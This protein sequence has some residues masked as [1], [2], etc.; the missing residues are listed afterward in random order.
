MARIAD[1]WKQPALEAG[2][3]VCDGGTVEFWSGIRPLTPA[4]APSGTLL[5]TFTLDTPSYSWNGSGVLLV[6]TAS[7]WVA[8]IANS[9]TI[10]FARV[11]GGGVGQLDLTVTTVLVGTG[12]ILVDA[13]D[14]DV[15]AGRVLQIVSALINIP[16]V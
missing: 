13:A 2:M 5:A 7:P 8:L 12:D 1:T 10:G 6:G 9:G 14:L 3:A 11:K 15:I 16:N 4:G